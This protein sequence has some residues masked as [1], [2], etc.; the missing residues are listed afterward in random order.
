MEYDLFVKERMSGESKVSIW[1]P[2]KKLK[3]TVCST[4]NKGKK[5]KAEDKL[6]EVKIQRLLFSRC[7]VVASSNCD[8]DMKSVVGEHELDVIPRSLMTSDGSLRPGSDNKSD[9]IQQITKIFYY[10]LF[11]RA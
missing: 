7:A 1:D 5:T 4:A 9:L 2:S 3:L 10:F 8:L 6:V 11:P